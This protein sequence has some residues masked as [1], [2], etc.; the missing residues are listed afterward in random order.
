[1][2]ICNAKIASTFLGI[3]GH[4][5]L[6]FMVYLEW[7]NSAQGLGGYC[8][9]AQSHD[10]LMAIKRILEVVGVSGW[11]NLPGKLV[12]IKKESH[13]GQPILGN[14]LEDKWFDLAAFMKKGEGADVK[15]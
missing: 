15:A 13:H 9:T 1:M 10:S 6:T 14:I 4:G 3:E 2:E 8:L 7:Q 12:R 5:L 11:E